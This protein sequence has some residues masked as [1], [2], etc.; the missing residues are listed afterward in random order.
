MYRIFAIIA[1]LMAALTVI[2]FS[3]TK[4][5]K[6]ASMSKNQ[7]TPGGVGKQIAVIQ[8]SMGT[9]EVELFG[10]DAPKTVENFVKLAQKKYFDGMRFHR[11]VPGFVIQ[12]GDEF[13]KDPK[14]ADQWGTG[15]ESIWGKDFEDELNPATPSYQAGYKH[16]VLAMANKGPNT[17]SSQ[18]FICLQDVQLPHSYTIFGK[19]TKGL[20]VVDKIGKVP[21]DPSS[22]RPRSDVMLKHLTIK[23]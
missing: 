3:Q 9:I 10:N 13:S 20:D 2:S 4:K 17:N 14:K 11:V 7:A 22:Q 18:F 8:T 21:T 5:T 1:M 12:T 23:K 6:G 15:G 16:G 19:V